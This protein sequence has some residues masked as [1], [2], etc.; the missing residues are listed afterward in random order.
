MKLKKIWIIL[1]VAITIRLFLS[2]V[3]FHPDIQAFAL[4]G[5]LIKQGNILNL[6]DLLSALP[7]GHQILKSYPTYIFN[8]PPLIYL[9]HGLF[10]SSINI[11]SNQNFLEMFLF[12]VPEA[13]KNPVVFIHLF[14]LKLPLMVFDLGTGFLL[15]KF[16]EDKTKAVIA[17][18]LWLF[19][20]V[21]LH[22]T[23]MMGQFDIIPVFFTILSIL[24][25]KNK[26]TFKTG[27]LAALSLGLGAAFKI[28]P[29][30]FVVPLISLF[31]SWKIRSLIAF[32]ALSPYILSILPFINS[33]GFRSNALVASQTTKS[34]YSQIAVSGGESILLFLSALAF[35]YFLFLHNTISPS[36]VWRYFFIT[37]LLFF[38]FTHTHPQWFLWLTPFLIIEL[39]ESKFKNVYAGILALMSFIGLLFFFDPSLTIGLFAP[40]WRDL[41]SSKSLWELLNISIDFNFARSF[42]HSIFVGAGLF[43]LY[44]YFPRSEEEK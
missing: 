3:T 33:S 40:L 14:T 26:L 17:L 13:L 44:I 32:S 31:K 23:Y 18:V 15:F 43:Y 30:F 10:Y 19:N 27:L 11:F 5:Y 16:F 39:V 1:I 38:I 6:Y 35:F 2:L 37:L 25:L 8:Y 20:P 29:L 21:T 42:L 9:W 7:E 34:F 22:A 36:R 24:L 41:Y 12:N 4:A 28:Y